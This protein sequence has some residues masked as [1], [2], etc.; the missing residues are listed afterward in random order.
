MLKEKTIAV[1]GLNAGDNPGPGVSVIRS[2]RHEAAFGGRIVGLSYD[3][4]EPGIYAS[5]LVDDAFLIPYPSQGLD[6]L[7]ARL[8][9]IQQVFG[10]DVLLPTLDAELPA[11]ITLAD[12]LRA[13][14]I[15]TWLPTEAQ[16]ERRCKARL[17]KLGSDTG[18]PT[19][20]QRVVTDLSQLAELG[21][22]YGYPLVVK[23]PFYG[24]AICATLACAHAAFHRSVAEWGYPVIVQQFVA[25]EEFCVVAVGDGDGGLIGALPMRKQTITDKGKGWAGIA[26]SDGSLLDLAGEFMAA[27]SWRGPCELEV[28]R[29]HSGGYHLVEINPRFPAWAYLAAGAGMNLALAVAR[30]AA[31]QRLDPLTDYRVGTM[32]VRIAIDQIADLSDFQT[33]STT[34]AIT[35]YPRSL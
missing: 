9:E 16:Y 2:L 3:A 29:D 35:R 15:G 13:K 5:D 26:I 19:L 12:E 17:Q 10:I 22:A 20:P 14:G 11:F 32:F 28:L 21:V 23:G 25:G 4:L 18:L 27:T 1:T 33:I 31:G 24:A 7:R 30:L 34:G 8:D 6:A